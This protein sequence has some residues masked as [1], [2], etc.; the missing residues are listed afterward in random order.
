MI[1]KMTRETLSPCGTAG[2]SLLFAN[3]QAETQMWFTAFIRRPTLVIIV[4][5][6]KQCIKTSRHDNG[7]R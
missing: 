7:R 4:G 6:G 2:S 5:P 1:Y 3:C